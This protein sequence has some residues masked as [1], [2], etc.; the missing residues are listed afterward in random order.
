MIPA[1]SH[2]EFLA[3]F[4]DLADDRKYLTPK[5]AEQLLTRSTYVIYVVKSGDSLWSIA[6]K[7]RTTI[8]KIRKWNRLGRRP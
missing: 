8:T 3:R 7:H 4:D 6:R 2:A 5:R 1:A